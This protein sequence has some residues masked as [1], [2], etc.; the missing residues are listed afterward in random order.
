[1]FEAVMKDDLAAVKRQ[2]EAGAEIRWRNPRGLTAAEFAVKLGHIEIA[3]FL[4]T[5]EKARASAPSRAVADKG[6]PKAAKKSEPARAQRRDEG[7]ARVA[8]APG[9]A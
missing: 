6:A 1:M 5:E 3:N 8:P 7:E 2:V 9:T 4:L